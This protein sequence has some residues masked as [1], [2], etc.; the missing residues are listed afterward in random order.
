MLKD[1]LVQVPDYSTVWDLKDDKI[2]FGLK[3]IQKQDKKL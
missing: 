1:E 2:G 3:L